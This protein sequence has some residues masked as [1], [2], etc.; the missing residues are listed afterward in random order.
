LAAKKNIDFEANLTELN[1]IVER[2]EQSSLTLEESLEHFKRGI[3]LAQSCQ[4]ALQQ[5]E[6]MIQTLSAP[7]P[8]SEPKENDKS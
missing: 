6:Q 1:T 5:A 3:H 2:M 7:I 8:M 4:Q